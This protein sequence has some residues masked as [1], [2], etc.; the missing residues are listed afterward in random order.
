MMNPLYSVGTGG[1]EGVNGN[2]PA[3]SMGTDPTEPTLNESVS[4]VAV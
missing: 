1:G 2:R 3:D 4:G